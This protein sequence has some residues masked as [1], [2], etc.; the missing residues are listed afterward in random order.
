MSTIINARSPRFLR[1]KNNTAELLN[2]SL[3]IRIWSGLKSNNPM[4]PTY[5]ISKKPLEQV[6]G[7]LV[8]FE[9]SE[10]IRDY[11]ETEYF[12]ETTDAV[13]VRASA[14]KVFASATAVETYYFLALD[15]FGYFEEGVNP[16]ESI[17]PQL[18]RSD[19]PMVLQSN[20]CVQFVRGR[21]IKIPVFSETEPTVVTDIPL[22]VWNFVDDFWENHEPTWD[23][24]SVVQQIVDS[25]DT[26]DKIQYI[27][28][29]TDNAVT[30]DTITFTS[31]SGPLQTQTITIEEI[32]EPKF[33]AYR[34]A[35]YNKFGA[36][37][38]MWFPNKSII[39]TSAKSESYNSNIINYD[40]VGE[41]PA[42]VEY[43]TFRHSKKRFNVI[44]TQGVKLN[45]SLLSDCYNE[46]IEQILMSESI[47]VEFPE[48]GS[49]KTRPVILKTSSQ[50][51][52]TG[53]NDKVM[54][55]YGFDFDFAYE[56]INNV[57]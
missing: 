32:C 5:T 52:K 36:I 48:N 30:G 24:T 53:T 42:G 38:T 57:R 27:V 49:I 18:G 13:W 41:N 56:K 16:R 15:G 17:V 31:T 6:V 19:T 14:T 55:Q 29:S 34:G 8:V 10:L 20:M 11:L 46:P 1:F 33:D 47:W 26:A 21:D 9:I 44:A 37:Q 40:A 35:F 50:I 4:T 39:N 51:R 2:V 43:S 23:L 25:D 12:Q 45:T 28:I 3:D 7:N 54:I 22:G